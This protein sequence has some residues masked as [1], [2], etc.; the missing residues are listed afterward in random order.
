MHGL[1]VRGDK[2]LRAPVEARRNYFY[3]EMPIPWTLLS[4]TD[5][6]PP[7]DLASTQ[8]ASTIKG[9]LRGIEL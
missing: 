7:A 5:M 3:H 4:R 6:L 2:R 9:T 1:S 8:A